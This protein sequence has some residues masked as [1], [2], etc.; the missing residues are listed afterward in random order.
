MVMVVD[1]DFARPLSCS[2]CTTELSR[3]CKS[4]D[5]RVEPRGMPFGLV[6]LA[7]LL[8]ASGSG[9]EGVA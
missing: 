3:Y 8:L 2:P 5:Q 1:V 6:L 7:L 9:G 4:R